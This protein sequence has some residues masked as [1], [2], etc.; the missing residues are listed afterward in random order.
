MDQIIQ[1][2][3]WLLIAGF[4]YWA[5]KALVD[6]VPIDAWF[7][8]IISVLLLILVVAIVLFKIIIPLIQQVGHLGSFH[9]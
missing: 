3:I 1:I 6:L 5:I 2:I 8:Q 9:L 4:L 7:K